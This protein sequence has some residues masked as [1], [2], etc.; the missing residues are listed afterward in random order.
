MARTTKLVQND[1]GFFVEAFENHDLIGF[2]F[3]FVLEKYCFM[4]VQLVLM[5]TIIPHAIIWHN[6]ISQKKR[7][8]NF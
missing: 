6:T 2:S 5:T 8:K 3:F 1:K 7:Y 4:E